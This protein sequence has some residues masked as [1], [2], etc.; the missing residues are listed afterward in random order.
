MAYVWITFFF[1]KIHILSYKY[2]DW[3]VL[4]ESN[5]SYTVFDTCTIK[6]DAISTLKE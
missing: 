6:A 3:N 5:Y 1:F 2:L 4:L